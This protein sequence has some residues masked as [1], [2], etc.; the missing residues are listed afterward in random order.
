MINLCPLLMGIFRTSEGLGGLGLIPTIQHPISGH[1]LILQTSE[2]FP[3][4]KD[5]DLSFRN[6]FY[7]SVLWTGSGFFNLMISYN[8]VFFHFTITRIFFVFEPLLHRRENN[9]F[10]TN[11]VKN[12]IIKGFK[13]ITPEKWTNFCNHVEN[14]IEPQYW[15]CSG[16]NQ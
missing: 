11:D 14:K 4:I 15:K 5:K 2:K 9:T 6:E 3:L 12:L 13:T 16:K 8:S 7:H 10:K 1:H